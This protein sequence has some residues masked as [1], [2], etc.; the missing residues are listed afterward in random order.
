MNAKVYDFI[1]Y[2]A[3]SQNKVPYNKIMIS[4]TTKNLPDLLNLF[5]KDILRDYCDSIN[6]EQKSMFKKDKLI[7]HIV[8]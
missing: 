8:K 3:S 1:L 4:S 7:K 5:N 6:V 2:L